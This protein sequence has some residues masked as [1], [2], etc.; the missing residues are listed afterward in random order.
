MI[1]LL[2]I[3]EKVKI[4]N[5]YKVRLAIVSCI[6]AAVT[7]FVFS[8]FLFPSFFLAGVKEEATRE[9]RE[10]VLKSISVIEAKH[11]EEEIQKTASQLAVVA[12]RDD[13]SDSLSR[14]ISAVAKRTTRG[15]SVTGF[16][17]QKTEGGRYGVNKLIVSG[18]ARDRA[19]LLSFVDALRNETIFSRVELPVSNL[20]RS[21]DISF[22]VIIFLSGE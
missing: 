1:N 4:K 21:E 14:F 20:V 5:L 12:T 10:L 3:E 2:P 8:V 15:I 16:Y 19:A 22:S 6:A 7:L 11:T 18:T 17:S 13:V 9:R